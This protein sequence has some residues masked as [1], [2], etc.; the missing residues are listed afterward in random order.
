MGNALKFSKGKDIFLRAEVDGG[1]FRF[2][3]EDNGVGMEQKDLETIFQA[4]TQIESADNR[5]EGGTGLGLAI[6]KKLA[7]AHGGDISVASTV[8]KGTKFS[9]FFPHSLVSTG[10]PPQSLAAAA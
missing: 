4:F 1:G 6:C 9:V 10:R 8:G 7:L 2:E 5:S 3:V